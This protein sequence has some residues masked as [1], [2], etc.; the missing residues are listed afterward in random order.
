MGFNINLAPVCDIFLDTSN[1]CLEGRCFGNTPE[2]V[3]QFVRRSVEISRK[4]GLISCLKHFPGLGAA[5]IDPHVQSAEASFDELQWNHRERIPFAA[6]V[7]AGAGM[8]M[9]THILLPKL[10][11][12]MVT[13]SSK[14]VTSLIRNQLQFDG[15]V[16]TDDL[17]MG[18]ALPLGSFGDRAVAAFQ[19]GHD[20]LL[21]GQ[22]TDASMEA[23]DDLR[24]AID[25][26]EIEQQK[27]EAS[28]QRV[29]GLKFSL[30][31]AAIS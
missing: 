5:S 2:R 11:T 30:R 9:T 31:R 19:A 21:F 7:D 18:G 10:D 28:L 14:I 13:A 6:G 1:V 24:S 26:R 29:S 12:H 25:R 27:V 23:Y 20:V 3:A 4:S 17:C 16:I 15:I 8:I 22:N